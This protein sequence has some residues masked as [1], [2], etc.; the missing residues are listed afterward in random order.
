[1]K[2]TLMVAALALL[3]GCEGMSVA[4]AYLKADRAT[5]D[6]IAPAYRIYVE[7]DENLDPAAKAARMRFVDSWQ[8]RLLANERKN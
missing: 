8:I 7:A 5:Y 2:N 1:M 4:D 3:C 6:V